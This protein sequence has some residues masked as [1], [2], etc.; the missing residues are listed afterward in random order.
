MVREPVGVLDE[1]EIRLLEMLIEGM[2]LD[3]IARRVELSERT[4]RRRL[5]AMCERAGVRS[6]IQLAVWAVRSGVL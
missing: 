4:L 6:P 5:R 3:A 2:T 1:D